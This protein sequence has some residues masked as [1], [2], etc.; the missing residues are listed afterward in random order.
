MNISA[1]QMSGT[2]DYD[3]IQYGLGLTSAFPSELS[4]HIQYLRDRVTTLEK[5]NKDLLSQMEASLL[6]EY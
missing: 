6:D 3:L 4:Q 2:R 5:E 1:R